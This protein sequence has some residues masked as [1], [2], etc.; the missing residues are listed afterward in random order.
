MEYG[1]MPQFVCIWKSLPRQLPN[2]YR[3]HIMGKGLIIVYKYR[4]AL[5]LT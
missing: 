1:L 3:G 2:Y 5:G 4:W